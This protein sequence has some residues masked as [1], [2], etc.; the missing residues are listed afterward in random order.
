MTK[1]IEIEQK[2]FCQDTEPL[3]SLLTKQG[4][5]LDCVCTE[6]DEYFTDLNSSFVKNRTC[7]RLRSTNKQKLELTFKGKSSHFHSF[8]AKKESNISLD[9]NEYDDIVETLSALGFYSYAIVYKN[10]RIYTKKNKKETYNIML[11][12]VPDIG[13][14]VEFEL[15]HP[16][17]KKK[18]FLLEK[19]HHFVDSFKMLNLIP[20]DLPYRDFIAR[21]L[22]KNILP[23]KTLKAILVDLDGTLINSEKLFFESYQTVLFKEY[24]IKISFSEYQEHELKQ[25]AHLL[26]YLQENQKI[27]LNIKYENLMNKVY[28]EYE[29]KFITLF[30]S[31]DVFVNFTLLEQLKKKGI[32]IALVTTCKKHFLN[33]LFEK[34]ACHNLFDCVVAREDVSHLKPAPDAYLKALNILQLPIE[35]VIAVEDSER[36]IKSAMKCGIKTI[37]T[38]EYSNV[39]VAKKEIISVDKTS[40]LLLTIV[41][42]V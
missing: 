34:L 27:P 19:L 20:A 4:F 24:G 6:Q 18:D 11:D 14:F 35:N 3:L 39:L 26:E 31:Q 21:Q 12:E 36:G 38:L 9:I 7:L 41:N 25:N 32:K 40:R 1:R 22:F 29:H 37:Q 10:R 5:S 17:E 13:T 28:N 30:S 15:L 42:F 16:Y 8:F 23:K 2:F 33:I